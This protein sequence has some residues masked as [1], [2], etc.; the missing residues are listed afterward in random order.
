MNAGMLAR[1]LGMNQQSTERLSQAWGQAQRA[2][3]GVNSLGDAKQVLS[4][5]GMT[6]EAITRAGILLNSPLAGVVATAV[7]AD[8]GKARK[9]LTLLTGG[10]GHGST[11]SM[12]DLSR[13]KAGL[14]QL[15]G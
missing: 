15:K 12:D 13:L 5:F 14:Q 2:A 1:L 10:G 3:S 9:A 6:N 7:G 11:N 4:A 8:I